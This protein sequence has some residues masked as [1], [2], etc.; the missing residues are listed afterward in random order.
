[1]NLWNAEQFG[2]EGDGNSK[3]VQTNTE[4]PEWFDRHPW[5]PVIF[6]ILLPFFVELPLLM[7][8][9]SINPFWFNSGIIF[10]TH[11]GLLPGLPY[12]DPNSGIT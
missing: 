10:G 8:R 1:M 2:S 9:L 12:I 6:L 5:F 11:S 4:A 3:D 7:F